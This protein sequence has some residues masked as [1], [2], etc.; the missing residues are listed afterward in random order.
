[1]KPAVFL[2]RDGTI[3]KDN[4]YIGQINKVEFYPFTF[5]CLKQLQKKFL[6]FI[7]TNQSGIAKGIVTSKQVDEVNDFIL[8]KLKSEGINISALYSCPHHRNDNC[9]CHKPKTMFAELASKDFEIDLK[10][11]YMIGDHPADVEFALNIGAKGIYVLTGHGKKHYAEIKMMD[12]YDKI[13]V[14]QSLKT[15]IKYFSTSEFAR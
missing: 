13:N 2:D 1:M 15:A 5:D 12:Y 6:L 8:N 3:I 7:V 4:G 10:K 11:S 14:F 9:K